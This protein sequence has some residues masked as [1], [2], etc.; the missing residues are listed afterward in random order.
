MDASWSARCVMTIE[1][2]AVKKR[3]QNGLAESSSLPSSLLSC[4]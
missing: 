2:R 4:R 1:G 3:M